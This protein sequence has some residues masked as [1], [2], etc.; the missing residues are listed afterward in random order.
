MNIFQ[1]FERKIQKLRFLFLN[2]TSIFFE[3]LIARFS[4]V[5]NSNIF[6]SQQFDWVKILETNWFEIRQELDEILQHRE[7]LPNI[8]DISPA[9]Y[10]IT[11]DDCWKTYFLYICGLKAEQNCARCPKTTSIIERIPGVTTAF[12]SILS[13]HKHIPEHRGYYKGVIRCHLGLIVPQPFFKCRIRVDKDLAFWQEGKALIFDDCYQHEVRNDTDGI[14]VVLLLDV[15]R[16]LPFP[17]SAINQYLI[18][19]TAKSG[20]IQNNL[21]N[22]HK[23]NKSLEKTFSK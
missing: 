13:P 2:K 14:R 19:I 12:F 17:L 16:P 7:E 5:G 3:K 15:I 20:L 8:Q 11:Q 22:I 21:N 18:S 4:L 10:S 6:D 1:V 23:W 9:Q